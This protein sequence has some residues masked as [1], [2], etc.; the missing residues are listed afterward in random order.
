M[1]QFHVPT[2]IPDKSAAKPTT[3]GLTATLKIRVAEP[4][5]HP[6]LHPHGPGYGRPICHTRAIWT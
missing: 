1:G 6:A 3:N 4:E 5:T 2:F